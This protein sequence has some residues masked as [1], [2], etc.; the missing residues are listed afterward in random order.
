[1]NEDN[2]KSRT[3]LKKEAIALQ[4]IG[5]RLVILSDEQLKR[6]D[7]PRQLAE[8]IAAIRSMTSHGAR[9]RQ[10]QYIGTLMRGVETDPIERALMEI[11]QG[12]YE[13]ARA[14]HRLESWR[15]RLIAGDD[16]VMD[17]ILSV[18]PQTDRQRL[19][20]LVRSARKKNTV[21]ATPNAARNLFR[22]LKGLKTP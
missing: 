19:G 8:A 12:A 6:M 22:Y 1:M 18:Y 15:D 5:E 10:F 20:Q 17:E 3:Q 16:A 2:Q 14:F 13:Q 21:Q 4:K 7:L 11:E 9:R